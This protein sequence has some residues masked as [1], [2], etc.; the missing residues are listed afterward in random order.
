MKQIAPRLH[1]GSQADFDALD[2]HGTEWPIVHCAK[3]PWHQSL[4]GY[5]GNC[6]PNHPEYL[7][8]RRGKRL[9]LNLVDVADPKYFNR[10]VLDAAVAFI[11]EQIA[12]LKDTDPEAVL[13]CCNQGKSR[14]AMLGLIYLAPELPEDF[15]EAEAEYRKLYP[16]YAPA[17]GAREF[18]RIHWR[19]YRN[20]RATQ[21]LEK[22]ENADPNLDKARELVKRFADELN[23]APE[24]AV[25]NLISSICVALKDAG[26]NQGEPG[27]HATLESKTQNGRQS[28]P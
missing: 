16:E 12:A 20:R 23:T 22:P 27:A 21:A 5:K 11:E 17:N 6:D 9:Y 18:A 1:V 24:R 14:A 28:S 15:A 25:H 8:A 2:V 13:L 7:F 4:L 3:T 19:H 10:D 26:A